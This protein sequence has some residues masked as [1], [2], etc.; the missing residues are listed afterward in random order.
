MTDLFKFNQTG[1]TEDG[2]VL[3]ETQ[4][5]GIRPLFGNRLED[6]GFKLGP[7]IFGVGTVGF[8]D[9]DSLNRRRRR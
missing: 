4:P 7:E 6:A 8:M 2:K 9:K 5:T 1:T 3:G